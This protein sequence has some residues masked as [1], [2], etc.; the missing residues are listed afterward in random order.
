MTPHCKKPALTRKAI[1]SLCLE[2]QVPLPVER[3]SEHALCGLEQ[4]LVL[5]VKW[6]RAMNLIGPSHW[7]EI[8]LTLVADSFFLAPFLESLPLPDSPEC[9][10]LGAGAG[11]PG[12]PLRLLWERG[13]Y[14]LV[15]PREKRTLFL[16]TVLA[17]CALPGV[18]VFRG[19]A[20]AFM[21]DRSLADLVLSR[22]FMPWEKVLELIV[23]YVAPNG[24][25]IFLTLAPL[26][27]ELPTGWTAAAHSQYTLAGGSRYFW[28]LRKAPDLAP[29]EMFIGTR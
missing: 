9:W 27:G 29:R 19:R 14:T 16:Q 21:P 24:Y 4:Y 26:P 1:R 12:I 8:L 22:A 20:E 15:E 17:A 18:R 28:A 2:L 11:L 7:D 10:D 23:P 5:L 6:N 25:A 13:T 3:F